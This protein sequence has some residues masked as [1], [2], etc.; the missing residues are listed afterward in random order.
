MKLITFT[1][2]CYNS[3]DYMCRCIDSLLKAGD[4]AEIII[5]NDG[6]TDRTGE[7]ANQYQDLYP[8][9]VSVVHKQNGGHGSGVNAG[10]ER[11]SGLYFKV[12]DSDDWLDENAL[13]HVMNKLKGWEMIQSPVDMVV[14]NYVY[15]HLF[16]GT[17]KRMGYENVFRENRRTD[18]KSIGRFRPSQYLIMHALIFRTAVLKKSKVKLPEHTFYVDNIFA[19]K[20]LSYVQS[21]VYLNEDLYHYFL[22]REDQSVNE[23]VLMK[24]ID[25]QILVTKLLVTGFDMEGIRKSNP[26]LERYLIRNISIMMSISCIH[27]MLIGDE[28][29]MEKRRVLW[30]FVKQTDK[31]IYRHLRFRSVSGAT[32]LPGKIGDKLTM[33][34]YGIAKRTYQF[35]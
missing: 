13:F 35:N 12:V 10:L 5:V 32:Y 26:K 1:V 8:E 33:C 28:E 4:E 23:Q 21:M 14:C 7:I 17:T 6:S 34:G 30:E 31:H 3:E 20:P 2:P 18:W 9:I 22:G 27:L 24:R 19:N 11:A 15:D 29:A 25:Q 16:E